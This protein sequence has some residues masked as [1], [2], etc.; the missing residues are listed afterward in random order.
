[1]TALLDLWEAFA[2]AIVCFAAF[3][4]LAAF[5]RQYAPRAPDPVTDDKADEAD[6][7]GDPNDGVEKLLAVMRAETERA[8]SDRVDRRS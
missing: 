8:R 6:D 7:H 5:L 2:L 4:A 1:M 3:A